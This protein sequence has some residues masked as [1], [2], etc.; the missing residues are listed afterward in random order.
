MRW[1]ILGSLPCS[2]RS[3]Q[4]GVQI[5]SD[6]SVGM[7]WPAGQGWPGVSDNIRVQSIQSAA[8]LETLPP[9]LVWLT[10]RTGRIFFC[11]AGLMP[12][13]LGPRRRGPCAVDIPGSGPSWKRFAWRPISPTS[14]AAWD[15]QSERQASKQ[16]QPE[17]EPHSAQLI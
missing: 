2:K 3:L 7:C 17:G 5:R 14:C 9:V 13:N 1:W 10:R 16:R 15:M 11:S 6:E 8:S 12:R 4:A